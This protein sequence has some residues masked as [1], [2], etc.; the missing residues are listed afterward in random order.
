MVFVAAKTVVPIKFHAAGQVR[1]K[2][3]AMSN[4][5][6]LKYSEMKI[7]KYFA[8]SGNCWD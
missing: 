1:M 7:D 4:Y 3:K 6:L 8:V 5:P 2:S